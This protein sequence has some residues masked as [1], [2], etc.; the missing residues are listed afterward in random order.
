MEEEEERQRENS[1]RILHLQ[2]MERIQSGFA[3]KENVFQSHKVLPLISHSV[4]LECI[5]K[6]FLEKNQRENEER[7][8]EGKD[9][10]REREE[11]QKEKKREKE[12]AEISSDKEN[13]KKGEKSERDSQEE[14][15]SIF[16]RK[17]D[18]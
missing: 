5:E 18:L 1:R 15:S 3:S 6:C 17:R 7:E 12:R 9:E 4:S 16:L 11:D 13:E 10:K 8:R 14:F 2:N